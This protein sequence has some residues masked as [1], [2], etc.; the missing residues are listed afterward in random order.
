MSR[1]LF[2][3]PAAA[4]FARGVQQIVSVFITSSLEEGGQQLL[5]LQPQ[6]ELSTGLF[7]SSRPSTL[8]AAWRM[9]LAGISS[10]SLPSYITVRQ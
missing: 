10:Y 5:L 6:P 8:N 3:N 9:A 4:A 2:L 1:C 7:A